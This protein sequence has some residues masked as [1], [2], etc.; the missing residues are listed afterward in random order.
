[1][2]CFFFILLFSSC[3][4]Y[5][6]MKNRPFSYNLGGSKD[7]LFA[8]PSGYVKEQVKVSPNGGVEQFYQYNHGAYLYL[9]HATEWNSLN[10][11]FI[12]VESKSVEVKDGE[13]M[14]SGIDE[15]GLYWKEV[16]V[17]SL[18]WGYSFVPVNLL[19][20]FDLSINTIRIKNKKRN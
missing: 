13:F 4:G 12:T 19:P 18:K 17:D 11:K 5:T 8:V 15:S 7:I 16:R 1:M 2:K 6:S 10:Q 14:F 20:L 9:S 3:A